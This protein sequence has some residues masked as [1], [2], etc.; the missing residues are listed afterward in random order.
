MELPPAQSPTPQLRGFCSLCVT[1]LRWLLPHP[2]LVP[3]VVVG[4]ESRPFPLSL[5]C[6]WWGEVM[7]LPTV[8]AG[9]LRINQTVGET[10]P[11]IPPLSRLNRHFISFIY[12][13]S[14]LFWTPP[15]S[16]SLRKCRNSSSPSPIYC[17]G[18]PY[19]PQSFSWKSKYSPPSHAYLPRN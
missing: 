3:G 7:D 18:N 17:Y 4:V 13:G 8:L 9:T 2:P 16:Y 6:Y 1:T 19:T 14:A 10:R 12:G 15:L 11:A 5:G